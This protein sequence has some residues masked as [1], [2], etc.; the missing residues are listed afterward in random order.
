MSSGSVGSST[1]HLQTAFGTPTMEI[2]TKE[3]PPFEE[4]ATGGKLNFS[5]TLPEILYIEF[6]KGGIQDHLQ[7]GDQA[8]IYLG[9]SEV[10]Q[11]LFYKL[12]TAAKSKFKPE[13]LN[14]KN[15][16]ASIWLKT[17]THL[18]NRLSFSKDLGE[19]A[20]ERELQKVA[21]E[22]QLN[23]SKEGLTGKVITKREAQFLLDFNKYFLEHS[24]KR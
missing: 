5:L 8:I 20:K 23:M 12:V 2:T 22:V 17:R 7:K 10:M 14:V 18:N 1:Q 9:T 11:E 15:L 21:V 19:L 24:P 6:V 4:T 16:V 13:E 3:K